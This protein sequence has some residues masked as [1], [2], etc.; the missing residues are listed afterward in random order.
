MG[1]LALELVELA[2]VPGGGASERG[3]ILDQDHPAPEHVEIHRVSLQRG[4]PQVVEGLGDERHVDSFASSLRTDRRATFV[5][6]WSP[7]SSG[8]ASC[9]FIGVGWLCRKLSYT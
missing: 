2:V 3:H 9:L 6:V 4:G 5:Y 7:D 1:V 8:A